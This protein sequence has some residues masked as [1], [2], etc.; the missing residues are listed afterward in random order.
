L[1]GGGWDGFLIRRAEFAT[2]EVFDIPPM[3]PRK[4]HYVPKFYQR[5]FADLE[6]LLWV[7]DRQQQ[8]YRHL[9]PQVVC[10]EQNLYA[11]RP[12]GVPPDQRVETD[13]L[14]PVESFAATVIRKTAKRQRPNRDEL[15]MLGFFIGFQFTRLPSFGR[16]VRGTYNSAINLM[17]RIQFANTER[18]RDFL[19]RMR[20]ETGVDDVVEAEGMIEG[21]NSGAI[22]LVATERPF[23]ENMLQQAQTLAEFTSVAEWRILVAPPET[24]FIICDHPFSTVAPPE[25]REQGVSYGIPGASSYFPLTR[26][27]C[28]RLRFVGFSFD[29]ETVGRREV[30]II[31]QNLCANSD[32]FIMGPEREQLDFVIGRSMCQTPEPGERFLVET[33]YEREDDGLQKFVILR[34]RYFY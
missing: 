29:Y 24:G 16:A 2:L 11:V 15:D 25:W 1:G 9:A 34:R 20:D 5:G 18:V 8:V 27:L 31:N 32:R 19:D 7:Y 3:A 4:H 33:I 26:Q 23:L 17:A 6:G 22:R 14:S 30:R 21:I 10:R 13:I 12:D 28:L